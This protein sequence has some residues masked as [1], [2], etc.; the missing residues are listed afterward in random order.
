MRI[1]VEDSLRADAWA[2]RSLQQYCGGNVLLW[3]WLSR[4]LTSID[5]IAKLYYN[6]AV[7]EAKQ[8]LEQTPG[9]MKHLYQLDDIPD[10][11]L[12]KETALA[13]TAAS[14]TLQGER[15]T[16]WCIQKTADDGMVPLPQ[17]FRTPIDNE[18]LTWKRDLEVWDQQIEKRGDKG[19]TKSQQEKYDKFKEGNAR[20]FPTS[21][22]D[23]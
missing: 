23:V 17:W 18:V 21:S 4:G 1:S 19:L 9:K 11:D 13:E 10:L 2:L 20:Q 15:A 22:V 12:K 8:A 6:I 7:D 5:N 16:C 14:C 3:A